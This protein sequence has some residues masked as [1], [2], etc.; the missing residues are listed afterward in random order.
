MN[1]YAITLDEQNEVIR[2]YQKDTPVHVIPIAEA[3]GIDVYKVNNW[4]DNLSG[5]IK[6][7]KDNDDKYSIYVN[8]N[9]SEHRRRF[10]IA[11][12]IAHLLL[13]RSLIG[14]G[15]IDDGL[16]RSGFSNRIEAQAN[17]KAAD[18]LMPWHLLEP[19]INSGITDIKLLA[20]IFNVSP[21]AMSIRLGVPYENKSKDSDIKKSEGY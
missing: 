8:S 20:D 15:I 3:L 19:I 11:H 6:R 12:E 18:I 9:H 17:S 13:H 2:K 5:L 1:E 21:S 16:Y 7:D 4:S 14:D 10:T